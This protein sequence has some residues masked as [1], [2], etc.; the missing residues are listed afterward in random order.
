MKSATSAF[1]IAD[2]KLEEAYEGA[3]IATNKSSHPVK[4][5]KK[6]RFVIHINACNALV[7]YPMFR[8]QMHLYIRPS[9]YGSRTLVCAVTKLAT[10]H[11]EYLTSVEAILFF[12]PFWK[13]GYSLSVPIMSQ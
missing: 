11:D 7:G 9:L 8:Q 10:S 1:R 6:G 4:F 12:R 3:E 5:L 2:K 13:E